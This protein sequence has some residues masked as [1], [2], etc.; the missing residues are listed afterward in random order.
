MN[1]NIRKFLSNNKIKIFYY[2]IFIS[3]IMYA[4]LISPPNL[5]EKMT[6]FEKGAGTAV[7]LLIAGNFILSIGT[8]L[9][10]IILKILYHLFTNN[11]I[12][13]TKMKILKILLKCFIFLLVFTIY[14]LFFLP[15]YKPWLAYNPFTILPPMITILYYLRGESRR[16]AILFLLSI[17]LLLITYNN[18]YNSIN[19]T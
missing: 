18:F 14:F 4:F 15:N 17:P 13:N 11:Q 16:W 10:S 2:S 6:D 19:N 7:W 3:L 12:D 1:E 5:W 8:I 9:V